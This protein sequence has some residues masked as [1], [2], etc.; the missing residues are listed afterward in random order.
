MRRLIKVVLLSVL[1]SIFSPQGVAFAAFP[2]PTLTRTSDQIGT[3]LPSATTTHVITFTTAQ[4]VPLGGKI[5]VRFEGPT[6]SIPP[7]MDYLDLDLAVAVAS[8]SPFVERPLDVA[9]SPTADGVS[10]VSGPG[11]SLTVTLGD[12]VSGAIA[13]TSLIR[14]RLGTNASVGGLGVN[15]VTNPSNANSYRIRIKT[16]DASDVEIDN[17]TAMVAIITPSTLGPLSTPVIPPPTRTNGLPTGLLPGSTVAVQLS[18]RTD[19]YAL[20]RYSTVASTS[21]AAMTSTLNAT[22]D[23]LIHYV[24]VSGLATQSTYTYFVRCSNGNGSAINDDDYTIT[25]DIGAIPL[26]GVASGPSGPGG[27]GGN[28]LQPV[29]E[30]IL[31]GR[32]FPGG[33]VVITQDGAI[34]RE[35]VSDSSGNIRTSVTGLDRGTYTWGVY[36]KDPLGRRTATY[37]ST[38]FLIAK[39]TN[40]IA[41]IYLSPTVVATTT[42]G[43]GED[44]TLDGY[45]IGGT[46][47][48]ALMNKY[49]DASTGKV[50]V[51]TTTASAAGKYEIALPTADLGKGTYEVKVQS[52]ISASEKSNFSPILYVGIGQDPDV[53]FK[54]RSD[55]NKDGKV[56]LV[57]FSILLFHWKTSDPTADINQDGTVNLTDFSIMLANWTG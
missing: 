26:P 11:G 13:S 17:G 29:T 30:V 42:I 22:V 47:I 34:V 5:V 45:A 32:T 50:I 46:E 52:R 16:Y 48:T 2:Y 27:G 49:G 43:I 36:A 37:S 8:T 15:S 20:C 41:P 25:F 33:N 9:A 14:M 23:H 31:D 54:K 56:N 39:T 35:F 38:I 55:L 10:F 12:T 18:L 1:F 40:V 51:A 57:D 44:F 53:D 28:F 24:N 7:L 4:D 6:F 21:Y 19:V 3:S